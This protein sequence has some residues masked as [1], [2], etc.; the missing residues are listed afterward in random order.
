MRLGDNT[1]EMGKLYCPKSEMD[2]NPRCMFAL[3][4]D[5]EPTYRWTCPSWLRNKDGER[6]ETPEDY[7]DCP[8]RFVLRRPDH[9]RGEAVQAVNPDA[10]RQFFNSIF[11]PCVYKNPG[12]Q[13]HHCKGVF[14]PDT[15]QGKEE[16]RHVGMYF[17]IVSNKWYKCTPWFKC[18]EWNVNRIYDPQETKGKCGST[19]CSVG[20]DCFYHKDFGTKKEKY[21][22]MPD[23]RTFVMVPM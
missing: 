10:T 5:N 9:H 14:D 8:Q 13:D 19:Q 3:P 11:F 4:A 15:K 2:P 22:C 6:C 21:E 1:S 23:Y 7:Q 16:L 17:D 12:E 18:Q 20:E